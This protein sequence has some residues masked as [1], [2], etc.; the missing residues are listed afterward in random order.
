[1]RNY[2]YMYFIGTFIYIHVVGSIL[3][4]TCNLILHVVMGG[5]LSSTRWYRRYSSQ[6]FINN[7]TGVW[8]LF[9]IPPSVS[10]S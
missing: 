8:P 7:D 10:G 4:T 9:G 6:N 3:Y 2:M 1:M 5:T